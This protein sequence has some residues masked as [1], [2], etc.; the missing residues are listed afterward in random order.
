MN[1]THKEMID[2]GMQPFS[3]VMERLRHGETATFHN[4]DVKDIISLAVY[5]GIDNYSVQGS[6]AKACGACK[7][8]SST[9]CV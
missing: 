5:K 8:Y 1:V 7:I 4:D 2:V 3:C 9:I 6:R